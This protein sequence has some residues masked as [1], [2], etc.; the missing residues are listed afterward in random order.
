MSVSKDFPTSG[1]AACVD[2]HTVSGSGAFYLAGGGRHGWWVWLLFQL[3]WFRLWLL[4][5]VRLINLRLQPGGLCYSHETEFPGLST[6]GDL[7]RSLTSWSGPGDL[8][9]AM[10]EV[11][12]MRVVEG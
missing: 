1:V 12:A 11:E 2:V 9:A 4:R 8:V 3:H 7:L 5:I 10:R 6:T